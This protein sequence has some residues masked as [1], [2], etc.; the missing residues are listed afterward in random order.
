MCPVTAMCFLCSSIALLAA[1]SQKLQRCDFAIAGILGA[2]LLSV[3]T[4]SSL[5][6][7]LGHTNTYGW[8]HLARMALH[9]SAAFA[10]AGAAIMTWAWHAGKLKKNA[11]E[12]RPWSAGVGLAAGVLGVWQALVAHQEHKMFLISVTILV[13]GLMGSLLVAIT[14]AQVQQARTQSREL[15]ESNRMLQQ[16]FDAA[17]DGLFMTDKE[18]IIVGANQQTEKIFGYAVDELVGEPVEILV[19]AKRRRDHREH[20]GDY[21]ATP[22]TRS[23]G[24]GLD[25][26]GVHK[27]G[28]EVPLEIALSRVERRGEMLALSAVR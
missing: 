23:M 17:P 22:A 15:Q 16:L 2:I 12:W 24:H 1:T 21:F 27:S 9:T 8:T 14:I 5:G 13:G 3:G 10:L 28:K 25:L 11:P 26:Y 7:L 18:G 6:Y 20:R 19:P 4:V